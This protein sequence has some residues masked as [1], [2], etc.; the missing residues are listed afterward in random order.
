MSDDLSSIIEELQEMS[1]DTTVPAA[2]RAKLQKCLHTLKN[3]AMDSAMRINKVLDE[4]DA[5]NNDTNLPSY[6]RTPLLNI[7]SMLEFVQ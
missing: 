1:T 4:I 6:V 5:I 3:P 2:V 7:S